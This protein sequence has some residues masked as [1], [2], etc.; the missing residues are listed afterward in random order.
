MIMMLMMMMMIIKTIKIIIII[1]FFLESKAED[2]GTTVLI[3]VS[4]YVTN[5]TA[6]HS[7]MLESSAVPLSKH[8]I[9]R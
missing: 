9:S 1:M 5:D 8:D 7:I 2:E 6:S 3:N 4:D